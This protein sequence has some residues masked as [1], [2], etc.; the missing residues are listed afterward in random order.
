MATGSSDHDGSGAEPPDAD[1]DDR[2]PTDPSAPAEQPSAA[3]MR[4]EPGAAADGATAEERAALAE[5]AAL[6]DQA[7]ADRA[8]T[9]PAAEE[10]R[11]PSGTEASDGRRRATT[12]AGRRGSSS[13][14]RTSKDPDEHVGKV[15][16]GKYRIDRLIAKGG[17]GRVY[18][19]TQFPLERPVAIKILNGEYQRSDPQFVKRFFLEASIAAKLSHPHTITVF[20]YGEGDDGELYIAMELL[21]GRPLSRVIGRDGPY[22]AVTTIRVAMQICRA[23]REAH[24][25][26]I[27]HRDLKPGN[28]FILDDGEVPYAKVLDFGLVKL[29]TPERPEGDERAGPLGPDDSDLTRTGTLLGSP[30]YMSPEQIQGQHLDPRTDIYSFGIILYQM[31]SGRPPFT[32]ST[33]VDVIYKHVNHPVPPLASINPEIEVPTELEQIIQRCLEKDRNAR[34]GSMD[35][36]LAFLKEAL[37]LITNASGS[38]SGLRSADELREASFRGADV[39][40]EPTPTGLRSHVVQQV[41]P[42]PSRWPIFV[43]ALGFVVALATLAYVLDSLPASTPI[44][45]ASTPPEV[46]RPEAPPP[47]IDTPAP[48]S[49]DTA[50]PVA[51]PTVAPDADV[52]DTPAA[53]PAKAT[54]RK[55]RRKVFRPPTPE[56]EGATPDA[57][58]TFRDNPY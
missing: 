33:G 12:K 54:K 43:A 52:E 23:L 9:D 49:V 55:R 53:P 8:A 7:A 19:A 34:F 15:L 20:D 14:Y 25:A 13:R 2:R 41:D 32:G 45:P 30:K 1:D 50:P 28:I 31:V 29:F 22:D 26:G 37:T 27:I 17:M 42:R 57:G 48:S 3:R 35:E 16:T 40:E 47:V 46:V 21:K 58:P 4:A 36:L 38:V 44:S 6:R 11:D 39:P 24:D 56:P 10:V 51:P 18:Q 5:R